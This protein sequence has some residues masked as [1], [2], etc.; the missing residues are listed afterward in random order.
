M[1]ARARTHT[2][3]HKHVRACVRACVCVCVCVGGVGQEV[4]DTHLPSLIEQNER[5]TGVP[6]VIHTGHRAVS[7]PVTTVKRLSETRHITRVRALTDSD[8]STITMY[9]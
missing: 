9:L 5:S 2:H 1:H 7:R 3:T 8:H 6:D 4:E